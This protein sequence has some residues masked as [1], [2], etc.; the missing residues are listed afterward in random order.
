[1]HLINIRS[2]V[3]MCGN[4]LFMTS[5]N[6][7]NTRGKRLFCFKEAPASSWSEVEEG[8]ICKKR[9]KVANQ[10]QHQ[11]GEGADSRVVNMY[12]IVKVIYCFGNCLYT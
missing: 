12:N 9:E 1:M 4:Y 3:R 8:K 10:H 7:I 6:T 11:I 5:F 2:F